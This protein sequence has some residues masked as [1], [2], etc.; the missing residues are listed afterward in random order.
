MISGEARLLVGRRIVV[1]GASRG[2]GRAMAIALAAAGARIAATGR[3]RAALGETLATIRDAGGEAEGFALDITAAPAVDAFAQDIWSAWD[4]IDVVFANAGISLVK[5]A[6][7]TTDAEFARV[8]EANLMG[9]FRT[10]RAFG[11]PMLARGAGKLVTVTSDI[12]LRGSA[13]WV[14]YGASKAAIVSLTKT[15]AWE[16]APKVTVNSIAPGAFA[17]DINADLLS[18]PAILKSV[19]AATP[20]ARVGRTAEIGPLAVLLAGPGSDFMTG[21]VISIDG[22]IQRS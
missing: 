15:L 12:G 6:L 20:L 10:L 2:L 13:G 9:T 18:D 17:T 19:E 7:E 11:R 8:M 16:W 4:G 3:D 14:A 1:T 22:G 5:P 21:Q